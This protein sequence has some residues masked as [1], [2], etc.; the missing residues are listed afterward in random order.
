MTSNE[1]E[2]E[3]IASATKFEV[4]NF[5]LMRETMGGMSKAINALL[6]N[7]S[8]WKGETA[9][10]GKAQLADMMAVYGKVSEL[11]TKIEAAVTKANGAVDVAIERL[12]G[13]PA[14]AVPSSVLNAV[15]TSVHFMGIDFPINGAVGKIAS[16]LAAQREQVARDALDELERNL[17][18]HRAELRQTTAELNQLIPNPKNGTGQPGPDD[19][20]APTGPTVPGGP[21]GPGGPSGSGPTYRPWSPTPG[22]EGPGGRAPSIDDPLT[23]GTVPG[24][25]P[26]TGTPPWTGMPTPTPTPG[27]GLGGGIVPG[28]GGAA[29][30]AGLAAA[31][32]VSVGAGGSLGGGAAGAGAAGARLGSGLSGSAGT[33]VG[34]A[35][36]GAASGS[37][38]AGAGGRGASSVMGGGGAGGGAPEKEKRSGLGGL[39]A[40]KLEDDEEI[41]PR[42]AAAD[43]GG[44]DS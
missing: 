25:G 28:L 8:G 19:I 15:G 29:G 44:R 30:A 36:A 23:S 21:G 40:P 22:L 33:G 13:L 20:P 37:S 14:S 24:T 32:R 42:S 2:L 26:T 12:H 11:T 41:G 43:A 35:G 4:P 1:Q 17:D 3:T 31:A 16:L 34:S 39:I 6:T 7:S 38:A 5:A 9:A 18:G 10:A 27:P